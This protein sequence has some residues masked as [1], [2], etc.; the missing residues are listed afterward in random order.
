MNK[1]RQI[2]KKRKNIGTVKPYED[3]FVLDFFIGQTDGQINHI[4]LI[5]LSSR[6]L[7]KVFV[8]I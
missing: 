6:F 5:S 7:V 3:Y 2:E 1:D 8:L 4:K